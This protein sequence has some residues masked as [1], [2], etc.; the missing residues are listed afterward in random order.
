[1]YL[2]L[3]GNLYRPKREGRKDG[4]REH[5]ADRRMDYSLE[6]VGLKK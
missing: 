1:M 2:Y 6:L 3:K 5:A 4:S